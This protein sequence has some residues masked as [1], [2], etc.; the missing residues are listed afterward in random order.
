MSNRSP[1]PTISNRRN[2][3]IE[4]AKLGVRHVWSQSPLRPHDDEYFESDYY[5]KY[6]DFNIKKPTHSSAKD[7]SSK[8]KKNKKKSK[9][10]S[11]KKKSKS[12]KKKSKHS[13]HSSGSESSSES[14]IEAIEVNIDTIPDLNLD[15]DDANHM[16]LTSK[17][18]KGPRKPEEVVGPT[19]DQLQKALDAKANK[20]L[21][22]GKALLPGEGEAMAKFVEGTYLNSF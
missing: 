11:K 1:S 13:D 4:I 7:D 14:E 5:L 2:K 8:S 20:P 9:K 12:K 22:Y 15:F 17:H 18:K 10:S 3:R 21:D 6:F 16:V 19:P